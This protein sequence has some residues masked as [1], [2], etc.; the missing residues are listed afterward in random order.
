MGVL[1]G[2]LR[3]TTRQT[4]MLPIT[5]TTVTKEKVSLEAMMASDILAETEKELYSIICAGKMN[6]SSD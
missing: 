3:R 6:C 1:M 5:P 2:L 4:R